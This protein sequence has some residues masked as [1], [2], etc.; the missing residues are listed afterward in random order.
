LALKWV[1]VALLTVSALASRGS[2]A[3]APVPAEAPVL[4]V[5]TGPIPPFV[6]QKDS[7]LSGFSI[8]LWNTLASR[9]DL[10]FSLNDL[11]DRSEGKQLQALQRGDADV[12]L[13]AIA[14]TVER[15]RAVDFSIPYFDSGLQIMV[16]QQNDSPFL[17]AL[18]SLLSP[19]IGLTMLAAFAVV[20]LLAH[21]LWLV[22]RRGNPVFG[23]GY[24][25]GIA[26]G[27]W[28]VTLIIA[29]G[30]HGDRDAPGAVKRLTVALMWLFG[31]V[32]I[33]E[34]TATITSALTVQK[35]TSIIR[36]PGD[37][38]GK[39][40]GTVPGSV[41]ADYLR[42][43]GIPFIEV[44]DADAG[45]DMLVQAEI[46]A[47]VFEAPTLQYWAAV[48]GQGVLQIVGPVFR[49]EKYGIAVVS[50]SPLRKRINEALE[51]MYSDGSYEDIYRKWFSQGK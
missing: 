29:T 41:A 7:V 33:A 28:G 37:L 50:G 35:L 32:L 51:K 26:E 11:G 13:S 47:I 31:V 39:K 22:E 27:L 9:L 16:R 3:Q 30:E 49:P 25:R 5:V 46:Q 17:A 42:R 44:R 4:R 1:C 14:M 18:G 15:E 20:V 10:K 2:A 40:V 34:F 8:D 48:R 36:G 21:V 19:T 45:Y 12:A 23:R 38:P 6:I 43:Q 24:L